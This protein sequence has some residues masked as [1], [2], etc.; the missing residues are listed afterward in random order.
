MGNS[1]R[2]ILCSVAICFSSPPAVMIRV[3]LLVVIACLA[4]EMVSSVFPE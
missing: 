1:I 3:W 4:Q 2:G